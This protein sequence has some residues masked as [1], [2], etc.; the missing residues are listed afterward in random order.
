[1]AA[2]RARRSSSEPVV[3]G[4]SASASECGKDV[5]TVG[6]PGPQHRRIRLGNVSDY[7]DRRRHSDRTRWHLTARPERPGRT[8]T[9]S[10][11]NG[12][13][14]DGDMNPPSIFRVFVASPNDT[15]TEREMIQECVDLVN[16][17]LAR[18]GKSQFE[19]V[20]W[21]VVR[22]T[23]RRPQEAIN[24]LIHS[25]HFMLVV[26]KHK[27]GSNPGGALGYSSG[28]EEELF[29]ALLDL[30]RP[31]R[32]MRDVWVAFMDVGDP[33]PEISALRRQIEQTNALL[34]DAPPNAL[35]FRRMV[36]DRLRGWARSG[37]KYARN[38]D[39]QPQSGTD[40]LRADRLRR[41]GELL[42][43]LG[44]PAAGIAELQKAASIG[45]PDEHIALATMLA[46]Q[47]RMNEA[48][49]SAGRAIT[50][51]LERAGADINS[52]S[53][54]EAFALDAS[55]LR[56]E[57][58][59]FESTQRLKQA[60]GRLS[61]DDEYTKRVRSRILDDLGLA[62]QHQG[63]FADARSRFEEALS[64]RE[65]LGEPQAR[66]QSIVN[67]AR[68]DVAMDNDE[69]AVRL[70]FE[71]LEILRPLPPTALHANAHVLCSQTLLRCN[72]ASDALQHAEKSQVLNEQLGNNYGVAISHNM[73]AQCLETLGEL[74]RALE[75]AH[76]SRQINLSMGAGTV[77]FLLTNMIERLETAIAAS[78]KEP[79]EGERP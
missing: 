45:G 36:L 64:I 52:P 7:R 67:L 43:E 70:A 50:Y 72:R 28:T 66:A 32:A 30:G 42:T 27:W 16:Q 48:H 47:G 2:R 75:H 74:P 9:G 13:R 54:A 14:Y 29:T 73:V 63:D 78:P 79:E 68:N 58:K 53:A 10:T 17:E 37:E 22:G 23:A 51:Y 65:T 19:L 6:Q 38:I 46:R 20:G 3:T 33:A 41:K 56:R 1:M 11:L 35:Q 34:Y 55:L 69:A 25:C 57:S 60:L 59:H 71:A 77:P 24:D 4:V 76:A 18:E 8:D 62:Y 49:E 61:G 12:R 26:F 39:L 40:V 31:S 44:Q 15:G 21:E 5:G